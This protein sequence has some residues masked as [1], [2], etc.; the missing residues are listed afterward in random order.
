MTTL[1]SKLLAS[2]L[3][4]VWLLIYPT[5]EV[6]TDIA[7]A[8]QGTTTPGE[9]LTDGTPRSGSTRPEEICP[10]VEVPLTALLA[11]YGKGNYYFTLSDTPTFWFYVPYHASDIKR[12]EFVLMDRRGRKTIY[13]TGIQLSDHPGY[14]SIT[15]PESSNL[16]ISE[17]YQW[18][19]YLHCRENEGSE[20]NKT[21]RGWIQQTNVANDVDDIWYDTISTLANQ[22][23]KNPDNSTFKTQ[24]EDF[25]E[26][27]DYI[28]LK[29]KS[30][31]ASFELVP[32]ED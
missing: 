8:V 30:S 4:L 3:S 7:Q 14:I 11:N 6:H 19:F 26:S 2:S 12:M 16:E 20:P 1:R 17:L 24:W 31:I 27:S 13:A 28:D 32:I 18:V 15:L 29:D 21:V 9:A 25:L 22:Y 23:F 5:F 10:I